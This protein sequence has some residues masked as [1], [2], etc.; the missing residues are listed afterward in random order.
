MPIHDTKEVGRDD[1]I[2]IDDNERVIAWVPVIEL[3]E[4]PTQGKSLSPL[5]GVPS[6][7]HVYAPLRCYRRCPIG[8]VIGDHVDIVEI[9][10]VVQSD[11]AL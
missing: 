3:M 1:G 2:G 11:E 6:F 10:R 8:A 9:G 7:V 5:L 4:Q